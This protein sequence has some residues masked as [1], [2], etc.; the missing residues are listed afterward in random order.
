MMRP[1]RIAI[2]AL[3]VL[4]IGLL[5][6]FALQIFAPATSSAVVTGLRYSQTQTVPDFDTSRHTVTDPERVAAFTTLVKKYAI[7]VQSFDQSVN[8]RCTGGLQTTVTVMFASGPNSEMR[9]YDCSEP[10]PKGT[11]VTDA[12]ALFTGWSAADR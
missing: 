7:S 10:S 11:F 4:V 1:A 9:L 3:A 12:T 6:Y 2:G 8:D 5:L